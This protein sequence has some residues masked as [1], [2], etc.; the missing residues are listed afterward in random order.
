MT[1]GQ[2]LPTIL[3]A[4]RWLMNLSELLES[5]TRP[6]GELEKLDEERIAAKARFEK[7][8]ARSYLVATGTVEDR[9]QKAI[10][11]TIEDRFA[12]ETAEAKVKACQE[13]VRTLRAQIDV[14]RSLQTTVRSELEALGRNP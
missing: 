3:E 6:G 11:Q 12:L 1:T 10:L 13:R 7:Q 9:K 5:V 4:V 2:E 14:G 8:Y